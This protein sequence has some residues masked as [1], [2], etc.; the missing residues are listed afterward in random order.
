ME[1]DTGSFPPNTL[2][3]NASPPA[4]AL[5]RAEIHVFAFTLQV[6]PA[7]LQALERL[8]SPDELD[9]ADRFRQAPDRRR[10]VAGRAQLRVILGRCLRRAPQDLEFRYS[11]HGK[12]ALRG[13]RDDERLR[14]NVSRSQELGLVAVQWDDDL[15]VDVEHLR[16]FPDAL[17]IAQRFFAPQEF[18]LLRSVPAAELDTAFF[19]YWTRKEAIAKSIGLGLSHPLDALV[20]ARPPGAAVEQVV[21]TGTDEPALRWIVLVSPP[22]E[23]YVAAVATAGGPR[24]LRCWAS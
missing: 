4:V 5:P 7:R 9:R 14:F 1:P 10:Y 2:L 12:P 11:S 23:R 24:P 22:A 6:P 21:V 3:W 8:L 19:S 13:D 18:D 15:G 17:G 20:L 16:P